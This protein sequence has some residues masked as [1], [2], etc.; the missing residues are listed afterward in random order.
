MIAKV[1][2]LAE[3]Q[4]F[5]LLAAIPALTLVFYFIFWPGI[6]F[7]R[8]ASQV[9]EVFW[10][11]LLILAAAGTFVAVRWTQKEWEQRTQI[12]G[13][14][15]EI[16]SGD[17]EDDKHAFKG[18]IRKCLNDRSIVGYFKR[19]LVKE[20]DVAE[21]LADGYAFRRACE[22]DSYEPLTH[23]RSKLQDVIRKN[24]V[25][26]FDYDAFNFRTTAVFGG[27]FV[28]TVLLFIQI[29]QS[30]Y[31]TS[32]MAFASIIFAGVSSW[33]FSAAWTEPNA[34]GFRHL[35]VF[36]RRCGPAGFGYVG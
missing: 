22:I 11:V 4:D 7:Q 29:S 19:N 16:G 12:E 26:P 27:I 15:R 8:D 33:L 1:R 9:G 36:G 18:K 17:S 24:S 30:N 10:I 34:M 35:G 28:L 25:L 31:V 23:V 2:K 20:D 5:V 13:V 3:R 14:V 6:I 32:G 21:A